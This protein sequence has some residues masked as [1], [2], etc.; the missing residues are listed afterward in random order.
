MPFFKSILFLRTGSLMRHLTGGQD[1][2]F[3]GG[4]LFSYSSFLYFLVSCFCLAGF[5]FF[6]GFYSKESIIGKSSFV[7]GVLFYYIFIAACFFTVFY[8]VRL[9]WL[10]Y[11]SFF[12]SFIYFS[13]LERYIFFGSVS[14][15]FFKC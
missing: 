9:V 1:S 10:S 3:Y 12:K 5:P 7:R 2:R 14:L 6:I 4:S 15:L 11:S 13:S 8:R